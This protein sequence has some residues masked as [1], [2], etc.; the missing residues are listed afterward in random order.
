M[1]VTRRS[2]RGA[3]AAK[4]AASKQQSTLSFNHRVTKGNATKSG[5]DSKI[6]S[7]APAKVEQPGR[8]KVDVVELEEQPEEEVAPTQQEPEKTEAEAKAEKISDAQIKRYWKG[9]ED[10]RI[11]KRVH[12]EEL[13]LPEKVLRYFD[14]SSQYG[15]CIGIPRMKRWYRAERLGL[16]PPVEVLAVLLKEEK[17]G[18][19]DIEE[20][21]LDRIMGSTAIGSV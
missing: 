16:S 15:P 19:K 13:S 9:V 6:T 12:Q 3:A 10:A 11:A 2:T 8:E 1:P 17:Q 18:N 4:G 14:V 20:A 21:A 5:K 7:P